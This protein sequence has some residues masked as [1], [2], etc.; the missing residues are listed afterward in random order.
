MDVYHALGQEALISLIA[1]VFFIAVTFFALQAL[2][3]NQIVK[4]NRVFQVQL[5]YIFMS[6]AL[7]SLVAQFFLLVSRWSQQLPYL[8]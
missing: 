8:F 1:H 7:G 2:R 5:L 6:I 3:L 4:Q